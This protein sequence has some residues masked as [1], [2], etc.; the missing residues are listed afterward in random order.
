M[1]R[2]ITG[3]AVAF[4]FCILSGCSAGGA[5]PAAHPNVLFILADDLG[6]HDLGITGSDYYETPNLDRLAREGLQFTRAY[7]CS[8]VCSPARASIMTGQ[9]TARHGITDWIGAKT[10]VA[11]REKGFHDELLPP[12]YVRA[13]DTADVTVAEAF[14]AAGYRTFFAGKWHLGGEGSGPLAH[15]F[16]VNVGGNEKGSPAG[17]FFDPY[18]NPDLP[19]RRPGEQ[20]SRRLARETAD[21]IGKQDGEAPFFAM[22]SFYAV[23]APLQTSRA[24]WARFRA[25]AVENKPGAAGFGMERRLPI[26]TTQDH[27]VYA[28][29]VN[30]MDA[31]V[32]IV[33]DQLRAA[34]TQDNTIVVFTSDH[35]GVA[36]G[37]AYATSNLPLRGGKGYQWEGGLRVPL[38]LRYPGVKTWG[39]AVNRPVT[40]ADLFPTL[41]SIA[42]LHPRPRHHKDGIAFNPLTGSGVWH[43]R[44]LYW[45]YPHYGNQGGD[46]SSVLLSD[47]YK[48]IH[49]WENGVS[50]LY[51]LT[52]DPAEQNDIG[53][54]RPELT[55]AMRDE[56]L[57]WLESV[58]ARYPEPDETFDPAPA[59]RVA[60]FRR[61]T[62]LPRLEAQ[63]Q[64][65]FGENWRPNEDW[66]GSK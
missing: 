48:L 19:N 9:F 50:E 63:R 16:D 38:F 13:L 47:N 42:G 14:R 10:G 15:G 54:A 29:L 1:K 59:A 18:T 41:L 51:D 12:D 61:D 49:Y 35:G 2:S 39:D 52:A 21:W 24:Q 30:D 58:N 25:K 36:S 65:M 22:L 28:G 56:L 45:H 5:D 64:A 27:P 46:P 7:T 31:A 26:R 62:L 57:S 23:H 3:A 55:E 32:G 8:R 37:D 66:W 43:P 20:L 60:A 40:G 6:Y 53:G 11:W 33:L 34:G 4:L 17:G 44:N